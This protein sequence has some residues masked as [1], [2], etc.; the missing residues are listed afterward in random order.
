M[1]GVKSQGEEAKIAQDRYSRKGRMARC[2]LR[3]R[4]G[5]EER[6]REPRRQVVKQQNGFADHNGSYLS[7][8]RISISFTVSE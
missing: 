7:A 2:L 1:H 3:M 5:G 6:D 4:G 8:Y